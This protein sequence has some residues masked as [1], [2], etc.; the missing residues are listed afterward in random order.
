[1]TW[2][3]KLCLLSF[4]S[5]YKRVYKRTE[6][7][8]VLS[9]P[10]QGSATKIKSQ[11]LISFIYLSLI[12][13]V[14]WERSSYLEDWRWWYSLKYRLKVHTCLSLDLSEVLNWDSEYW[15]VYR[16]LLAGQKNAK[17]MWNYKNRWRHLYRVQPPAKGHCC[18]YYY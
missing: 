1:M 12:H 6:E 16:S 18:C 2:A 14:L 4:I 8:R 15:F 9:H 13:S 10:D 5:R 7:I 17:T 3:Y 11:A